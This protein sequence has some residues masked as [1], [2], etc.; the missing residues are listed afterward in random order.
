MC[1]ANSYIEGSI[2]LAEIDLNG[3]FWLSEGTG[4]SRYYRK[5]GLTN[6]AY[7][8]ESCISC[9]TPTPT[10][11]P[12][13]TPVPTNTP[14]PTATSSLPDGVLDFGSSDSN[15]QQ[16]GEPYGPNDYEY[17]ITYTVNFTSPRSMGGYV[18]VYLSGG[19]NIQIPFNQNDTAASLTVPCGCGSVCESIE[20][21]MSIIYITPTSTPVPEPPTPTPTE[22][23]GGGDPLEPI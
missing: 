3:Y 16:C 18:V 17:D 20:Y 23:D 12:T 11:L 22:E 8:Q 6:R 7:P 10:P 4:Q 15:F 14:T 9:P 21:V 19:S 1:D 5:Y 13:N 2:I